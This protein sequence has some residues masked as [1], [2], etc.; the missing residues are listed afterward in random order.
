MQKP[1]KRVRQNT[2]MQPTMMP[3]CRQLKPSM[4]RTMAQT[5]T[6]LRQ[7]QP[8]QALLLRV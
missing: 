1:I 2:P 4:V 5:N 8:V 7:W 3:K 6:M